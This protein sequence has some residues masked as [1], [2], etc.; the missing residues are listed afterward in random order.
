MRPL[1][2]GLVS[3]L[4]VLD[5]NSRGSQHIIA[6]PLFDPSS[7][8]PSP[9]IFPF[10]TRLRDGL[11]EFVF[12]QHPAKTVVSS[13]PLHQN[14]QKQYADSLVLRFNISNS[15]EEKSLSDAVA[16]LFLD[17]WADNE[18]Y[19]DIRLHADEVAPLMGLL[20]QSLRASQSTLIPDLA[21]AVY[22]SLPS[23]NSAV[24]ADGQA[25]VAPLTVHDNV[26][27]QDYQP[28]AVIVR[29]MR[30]LEAMFPTFVHYVPIG[31]SY[32]GR[33]IPA[34]RVGVAPPN[35][36]PT[37]P[38][39]TIVVSGGLHA[40][41]WISTS[42]VNY[43]AWSF[44]TAFGKESMITKLLHEFDIIFMPVLNPD[45]VEY[46]WNVDRLW[47]KSRQQTNFRFCRGMDLDHAFGHE[48]DGHASSSDPCSET[49]GGESPFQA[50]EAME[51][52]TWAK[53]QSASNV[54]FVGL[55]DLHSY[56]QQILFPYSYSC[57]V[58]PP[59]LEKLEELAAGIAKSIRLSNGEAYSVASACEESLAMDGSKRTAARRRI[60]PPGG[61]AMDWFYHEMRA[62]FSYQI[63][64]RDT[65]AYGFLLP[66]QYIIPAG[67]EIFS[68]LK[69]FGDYILGNNGIERL[70][71]EDA[72]FSEE[73][74]R[75]RAKRQ[76]ASGA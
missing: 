70:A 53:N 36:D 31:T 64:L 5:V 42:T 65:G 13:S 40:R 55:V 41:E 10:L 21:A 12:G 3:S 59:N 34:L 50:V 57:D 30:L 32:E 11:V 23:R 16:R 39:K 73:L 69:Y 4:L 44:I 68:A 7:N 17:V 51:L 24:Q 9:S 33:E 54:Q 48:W 43:V 37:E 1:A 58:D 46:T 2:L 52:A 76:K 8:Q 25:S 62:H 28:L 71:K 63:K 47:R 27:F 15:E 45:G 74:R 56:S 22:Q 26:F 14:I 72:P 19:V 38:R 29:W 66:R 6:N 20:P 61:S 60:E 67:E 49:Y 35:S 18:H 75:L